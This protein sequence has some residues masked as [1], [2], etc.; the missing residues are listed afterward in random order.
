[1]HH[2]TAPRDIV[3]IV[4]GDPMM[5]AHHSGR[6]RELSTNLHA[7]VIGGSGAVGRCLVARLIADPAYSKIT[8]INRREW[9]LPAPSTGKDKLHHVTCCVASEHELAAAVG[10]LADERISVAFCTLGTTRR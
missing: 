1:M 8:C 4:F 9:S 7:L 10:K 6:V 2:S 3:D 5:L